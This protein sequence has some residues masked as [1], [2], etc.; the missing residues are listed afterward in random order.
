MNARLVG[1]GAI[2]IEGHLHEHDVVI[3]HGNV[4][5]RIKKP[6]KPR[7]AGYG[8]TPLSADEEIP[9]GGT[10]LIVGTGVYGSLPITPDVN[11]QADR[12]GVEVVAA[13]TAE[14]C[15]LIASLEASEV[16]AIL[17]VTC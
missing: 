10:R 7:R 12:Q 9:W 17:H 11:Q 16:N 14:A 13:P 2:E 8:H 6:S 1:F 5:K 4:R 15:R 3:D